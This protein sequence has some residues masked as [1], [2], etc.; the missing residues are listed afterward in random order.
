VVGASGA[1]KRAKALA[2]GAV[3]VALLVGAGVVRCR[4]LQERHRRTARNAAELIARA[5]REQQ[6]LLESASARTKAEQK[7]P[8]WLC[9]R[10]PC[11][12]GDLHRDRPP[13][14]TEHLRD[15][16]PIEPLTKPPIPP[17]DSTR[18]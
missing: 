11:N 17:D 2:V 7:P 4:Y 13:P 9:D 15:P 16:V 3:V 8:G 6:A 10:E 14:E 12:E 1:S 5:E 18:R